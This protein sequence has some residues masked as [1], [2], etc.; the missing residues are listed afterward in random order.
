MDDRYQDFWREKR[1]LKR[2]EDHREEHKRRWVVKHGEQPSFEEN[3]FEDR[4]QGVGEVWG[5]RRTDGR[6]EDRRQ[7]DGER[8]IYL[9]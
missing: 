4:R 8:R 6:T 1:E 9:S 3:R 2:K 7:P 5:D